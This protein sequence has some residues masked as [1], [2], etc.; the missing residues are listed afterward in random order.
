[1]FL[2]WEG[3][4]ACVLKTY[5]CT[6]FPDYCSSNADVIPTSEVYAAS[7]LVLFMVGNWKVQG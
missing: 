1:M 3:G 6:K 7:M 4:K 5:D 2:W